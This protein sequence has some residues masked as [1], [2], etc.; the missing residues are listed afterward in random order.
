MYDI[1]EKIYKFKYSEYYSNINERYLLLN[2][3]CFDRIYSISCDNLYT[4]NTGIIN[5]H[6]I[7][8][9]DETTALFPIHYN[10]LMNYYC[11]DKNEI[12]KVDNF[13]IILDVNSSFFAKKKGKMKPKNPKISFPYNCSYLMIANLVDI[14]HKSLYLSYYDLMCSSNQLMLAFNELD[15]MEVYTSQNIGLYD[16]KALMKCL[17]SLHSSGQ[18]KGN[19]LSFK[20]SQVYINNLNEYINNTFYYPDLKLNFMSMSL[21]HYS[22][23]YFYTLLLHNSIKTENLIF[24]F[25]RAR[26]MDMNSIINDNIFETIFSI[27]NCKTLKFKNIYFK[28]FNI[29]DYEYILSF[30]HTLYC[31]ISDKI[32]DINYICD[33]VGEDIQ[34]FNDFYIQHKDD[35]LFKSLSLAKENEDGLW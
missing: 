14:T 31:V 34:D 11:Y 26:V 27:L 10:N 19:N 33:M 6:F 23:H 32:L 25:G 28:Q 20:Y 16:F 1:L 13:L 30:Q 3:N 35:I 24:R 7:Y 12:L 5:I 9:E 22:Y 18:L 21:N 8:F 17:V 4:K 29:P 15:N 2:I